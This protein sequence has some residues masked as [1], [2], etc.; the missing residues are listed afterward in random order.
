MTILRTDKIAGLESVNAITG[1]V[2]FDQ[3]GYLYVDAHDDWSLDGDFTIEC[4]VKRDAATSFADKFTIGDAKES[5]GLELYI[6]STGTALKVYSN[7][8]AIIEA[9][10]GSYS[11]GVWH[12]LAVV[13]SGNTIKLY[14]D[15]TADNN[16]ATNTATF[17]GVL[18]LGAEFYNN[19]ST[20]TV[21]STFFMSNFRIVK[22][23]ALYTANF[24]VPTRQL[25]N[26]SGTSI[27]CCQSS[28]DV[29]QEATGKTIVPTST[30]LNSPP[31]KTSTDVPDVG[32]DH[33]H[34][35]VLEG[36]IE[37][38]SLNYMTLPRGTTTQSN[39]GRGLTGGGFIAPG[40]PTPTIQSIQIQS[41]G[42]SNDFGDL[43]VA[44][45]SLAPMSS[46]TRG[47]FAGGYTPT[48]QDTI[49]Y[50]EIATTGNAIDFGNMLAAD[51]MSMGAS[52]S[53]RGLLAGGD[54]NNVIQ[55]VTMAS[56]GNA[57]DFGDL[58]NNSKYGMGCASPTRAIWFMGSYPSNINTIEYTTIATTGNSTDFGDRL[59]T[60]S[61]GGAACASSTR[62][63]SAGGYNH[64]T[65]NQSINYVEIATTGNA[66]D[67]GD[68]TK[69]IGQGGSGMS[70]GSR[71]VFGGYWGPTTT[72]AGGQGE[73]NICEHITFSTTGNAKDWG[74]LYQQTYYCTGVSDSHG[75]LSE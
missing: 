37:F 71:G 69:A 17:S 36:N 49:D 58:L 25:E 43:T 70:N 15:G 61:F 22:G 34:G 42:I 54:N 2:R 23:T 3:D 75:G 1:S 50:V 20:P 39:R 67:F 4:W 19:P 29:A 65:I 45:M 51:K 53:T 5:T 47:L 72:G 40:A 24:T 11:A 62:A 31:P 63:V 12:H 28:R 18:R 7:N 74:D 59:Y 46:A 56:T 38:P 55:Y 52:N 33:T 73:T 48:K 8:G 60:A 6:G 21:R 16:T 26:I 66:I 13:R 57:T 44:R 32:N 68:L 27:L 64:P 41:D 14:V 9:A 35:T 10:A 30:N